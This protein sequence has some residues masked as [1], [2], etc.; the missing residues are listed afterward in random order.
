MHL[1][2]RISS[3]FV[4]ESRARPILALA[5]AAFVTGGC[6]HPVLVSAAP[7]PGT[8]VAATPPGDSAV[9]AVRVRVPQACAGYVLLVENASSNAVEI[10]EVGHHSDRFIIFAQIGFTEVPMIESTQQFV[11]MS[12]GQIMASAR[13]AE[14][15]VGERVA[16]QRC[17]RPY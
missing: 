3:N 1:R 12:G 14:S 17:C 13:N 11:A 5:V 16:L 2:N 4:L 7:P 9:N 15:G 6:Y 8:P 10:Y